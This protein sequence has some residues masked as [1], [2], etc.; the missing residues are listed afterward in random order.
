VG[1]TDVSRRFAVT[2]PAS[3]AAMA[4]I[5]TLLLRLIPGREPAPQLFTTVME[6]FDALAHSDDP[7]S[8]EV[9]LVLRALSQLGYLPRTEALA[10]YIDEEF[11]VELSA[12]ALGQRA[13][14]VRAINES[15]KATG[16]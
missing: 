11:S 16:L 5:C 15:L 8:G 9:V 1:A 10:P 6:G 12:R 13:L 4:R 14:L 3:R 7:T 2:K